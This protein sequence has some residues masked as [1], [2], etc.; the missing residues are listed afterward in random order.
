MPKPKE[1]FDKEKLTRQWAE[2]YRDDFAGGEPE[3]DL[4]M[5]SD[6]L[7]I[8]EDKASGELFVEGYANTI[9]IDS[10]D[11]IILPSAWEQDIDEYMKHGAVFGMHSWW[12]WSIGN[13]REYRIDEYG[14]WFRDYISG[15]EEEVRV[16]IREKVLSMMSVGFRIKDS[17]VGTAKEIL[18]ILREH[19]VKD[20]EVIATLTALADTESDRR[21]RA[22]TR[23]KIFEHSIVNVGAN[24][25]SFFEAAKSQKT[26]VTIKSILK[27]GSPGIIKQ[28]S[29]SMPDPIVEI[30]KKVDGVVS[31]VADLQPV[32]LGVEEAKKGLAEIHTQFK[33]LKDSKA[34]VADFKAFEGKVEKQLLDSTKAL[35]KVQDQL[36]AVPD[37][38]LFETSSLGQ[39]KRLGF[40]DGME[41]PAN[42]KSALIYNDAEEAAGH[43]GMPSSKGL[44]EE[45]QQVHDDL[46]ILGALFDMHKQVNDQTVWTVNPTKLDT[47]HKYVKMAKEFQ[48]QFGV[49]EKAMDG[50][51]A[52]EGSEY[53]PTQLSSTLISDL[54]LER[55]V[56][57]RIPRFNMPTRSFVWPLKGT[58]AIPYIVEEATDDLNADTIT[59]ST[60][61]TSNL[62]FTA[63]G[64]GAGVWTSNEFIEDSII[65]VLPFI[66]QA[67]QLGLLNGEENAVINGDDATT[68][69]DTD[70]AARSAAWI[71]KIFD[72]LRFD[73][74]N[75]SGAAA[76]IGTTLTYSDLI[77]I[78]KL[79][80]K[81]SMKPGEGFFIV[82]V[83]AYF[84]VLGLSEFTGYSNFF[85]NMVADKGILPNAIGH[86]IVP[87]AY[88]RE[89]MTTSGVNGASGNDYTGIMFVYPKGWMSGDR[90]RYTVQR[91]DKIWRQQV[92]LVATQRL[93]FKKMAT[94]TEKVS[95][96]GYGLATA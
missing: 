64:M 48:H 92:A 52:G 81:Y 73:A 40:L 69:Q 47:F 89:D 38:P 96:F 65:A 66:R 7:V 53:L 70:D 33:E 26:M 84:K 4:K 82:S 78:M 46:F 77:A 59:A 91:E 74:L 62:T 10:V 72:G 35:E 49:E 24:M 12:E 51:T 25:G 22:I 63:K 57:K 9:K 6:P 75:T 1:S 5:S 29:T 3:Y 83:A 95:V 32:K 23:A 54:E 44:I 85:L 8:K 50:A 19:N 86:D 87:S 61:T 31:S 20:K 71:T 88:M 90:R 68:H 43:I 79:A 28:R 93:D 56:I 21:F 39:A 18:I 80:G 45:F 37:R 17:I 36:K 30:E 67:L 42:L 11:D 16:K 55:A 14:L 15:W 94:A 60:P 13:A 58:D 34:S 76:T 27:P 2:T 41:K